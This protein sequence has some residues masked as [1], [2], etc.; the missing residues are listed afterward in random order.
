MSES[1]VDRPVCGRERVLFFVV[2]VFRYFTQRAA[3]ARPALLA[4]AVV[5]GAMAAVV[6]GT[7][8]A[9][10]A[11]AQAAQGAGFKLNASD[12]RFILRQ[13]KI[14]ERHAATA[15]P[16]NPCGTLFGT[17]P[18]QV[19]SP[20]LPFGLRTVDGSCNN[21][22]AGRADF[23]RADRLFPRMY[24][25]GVF[26]PA[27]NWLLDHDGAG[28]G[29][30]NQ[31]SSY[32]QKSNFVNDSQPRIISNLIVD[33]TNGNPAAVASAPPGTTPDASG[34]LFIPNVAPDV[35][36]S[37][38]YNSWFTLFGQFFDHGL[39]LVNKGG[40][41]TVAVPLRSDDALFDA[42]KS[43]NCNPQ[44]GPVV[45]CMTLSRATNQPGPDGVLGTT[46]DIQEH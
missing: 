45:N 17:G 8:R 19:E 12:I 5:T 36:L 24:S 39:D 2:K 4:L 14:A 40:S 7:V 37:A 20:L 11:R 33:Q 30:A 23:G 29:T 15:T 6:A 28:P 43:T 10:D 3:S 44:L 1:R 42:T 27:E 32:T 38:P 22:V 34:T 35:G 41:G 13:I 18:D 26:R 9:P 46:D 16:A 21:L 31:T 25:P